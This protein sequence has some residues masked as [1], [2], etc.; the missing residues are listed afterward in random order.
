M[1]N[2]K[3]KYKLAS[4]TLPVA[5]RQ[6]KEWFTQTPDVFW[7][8]VLVGHPGMKTRV[9]KWFLLAADYG[10]QHDGLIT[11]SDETGTPWLAFNKDGDLLIADGYAWDGCSPKLFFGPRRSPVVNEQ[12]PW[13]HIG[14]WDGAVDPYYGIGRAAMAS[15][16]HDVLYQFR[17]SI[18]DQ[19]VP[20]SEVWSRAEAD[21]I[22]RDILQQWEHGIYWGDNLLVPL[23]G[24]YWLA[25]RVLG[26]AWA[27]VAELFSTRGK[28]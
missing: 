26:N 12:T 10:L 19:G 21:D 16:V 9:A 18:S 11:F 6:R 1:T 23:D 5:A 28:E 3:W 22:F 13:A 25:V 8:K 14:T 17:D 7:H 24:A 2:F 27:N 15:L 20:A 4:R